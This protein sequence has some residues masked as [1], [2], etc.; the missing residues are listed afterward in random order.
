MKK[1]L[2]AALAAFSFSAAAM[3]T[4]AQFNIGGGVSNIEENGDKGALN[5]GVDFY[6]NPSGLQFGLGADMIYSDA[7]GVYKKNTSFDFSLLAGFD[8]RDVGMPV[9]VHGG[10]GYG[11]AKIMDGERMNG[12]VYGGN[13]ELSFSDDFGVGIEYKVQD[14]EI[15]VSDGIPANTTNTLG[16][17]FLRN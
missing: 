1:Q 3:A 12:M 11:F 2:T 15:D 13:I 9:A 4:T 17:I 6:N 14:Y 8:L 5:L 10:V 7:E 16:Y